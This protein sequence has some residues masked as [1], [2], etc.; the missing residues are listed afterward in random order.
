MKP[1]RNPSERGIALLITLLIMTVLLGISA[2]LLNI[3]VKQFQFSSIGLASETAFQS[4]NAGMECML[5][6]DYEGYPTIPGKFDV[7]QGG[8]DITCMED[9]DTPSITTGTGYVKRDYRF[10]W[11]NPAVCTDVSIYKFSDPS[12]SVDMFEA[13]R[14]AGSCEAGV[15]CTV[16]QSRGY[17]VACPAPGDNFPPRTIERELTQRY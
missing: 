14:R 8:V 6:H 3:T 2:S 13:L 16:I 5:R 7:G 4:A 11:G 17:N 12:N 9:L 10:S 1:R 15:S